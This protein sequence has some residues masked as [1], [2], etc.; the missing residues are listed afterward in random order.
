MTAR[1]WLDERFPGEILVADGYDDAN[2]GY[3]YTP[4]RSYY[5]VYDADK[6][7]EL[8]LADSDMTTDDAWEYFEFNVEGAWVG[9]G[10]PVF[11]RRI[12]KEDLE[13]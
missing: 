1:E 4:G 12:S 10:T 3:A 13:D 8:L 5:V 6:C 11:M 2:L 9:E 7:I